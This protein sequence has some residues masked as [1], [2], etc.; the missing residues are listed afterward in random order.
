[1]GSPNIKILFL[2]ANP[3]DN[4][5]LNVYHE[6]KDIKKNIDRE[7][8]RDVLDLELIPEITSDDLIDS[9]SLKTPQI[10]HFSGHALENGIIINGKNGESTLVD[11]NLF[12]NIFKNTKS[13]I[14]L[15]V[16]NACS[17]SNQAEK[18]AEIVGCSIGITNEI[19]DSTAVMFASK[20]YLM[21][22]LGYSIQKAFDLSIINL[23]LTN[24]LDADNYILYPKNTKKPNNIYLLNGLNYKG[25]TFL[26]DP[27]IWNSFFTIIDYLQDI[28]NLFLTLQLTF[29]EE[30]I[31]KL[32]EISKKPDIEKIT[33]F[34]KFWILYVKEFN[35]IQLNEKKDLIDETFKAIQGIEDKEIVDTLKK[36]ENNFYRNIIKT[37]NDYNEWHEDLSKKMDLDSIKIIKDEN[38]IVK[39]YDLT[40]NANSLMVDSG[41]L[42]KKLI[43]L[44]H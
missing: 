26:H 22:A 6:F 31:K 15:V 24:H 10:L 37:L 34:R 44:I 19:N 30:F 42:L 9:I 12:T 23:K 20:F 28:H 3:H 17:T 8:Y 39:I 27:L 32:N 11:I 21:L 41:E 29:L 2:A 1:M 14:Q 25:N 38:T 35:R 13:E 43:E 40:K 5:S 7:P 16:L 33:F 4:I 18:I 36:I